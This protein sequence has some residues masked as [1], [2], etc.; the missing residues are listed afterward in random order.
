MLLAAAAALAVTCSL[1]AYFNL[2]MARSLDSLLTTTP[3]PAAL[4][5]IFLATV[6]GTAASLVAIVLY[7]FRARWFWRCLVITSIFWLL[8]MPMGS[9][10]GLIGLIVLLACRKHFPKGEAPV[11]ASP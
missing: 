8:A 11:M 6:G 10:L 9:V 4:S 5:L 3:L 2:E 1:A 7:G